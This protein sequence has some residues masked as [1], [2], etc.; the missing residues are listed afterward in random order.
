LIYEDD[1][2]DNESGLRMYLE[3]PNEVIMDTEKIQASG[4]GDGVGHQAFKPC[5]HSVS[6]SANCYWLT[7]NVLT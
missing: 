6:A 2:F 3:D 7:L 1:D 5:C 4:L